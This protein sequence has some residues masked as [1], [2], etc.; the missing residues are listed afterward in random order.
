MILC[1]T[2]DLWDAAFWPQGHDL[3]T[4][5]KGP[6]AETTYQISKAWVF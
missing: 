1:K 3:N 2:S 6:L 4:L 5:D